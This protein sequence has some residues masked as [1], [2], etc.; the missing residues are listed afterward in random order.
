MTE[1]KHRKDRTLLS[2]I[3]LS[4]IYKH[5]A[6]KVN[7]EQDISDIK[8]QILKNG[9]KLAAHILN[10]SQIIRKFAQPHFR[11]GMVSY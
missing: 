9:D 5:V 8:G 2:Y 3:A 1:S 10:Q 11:E 4:R 7:S 6:Q